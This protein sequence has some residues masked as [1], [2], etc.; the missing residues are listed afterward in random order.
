MLNKSK[1]PRN[2][3]K[4][5]QTGLCFRVCGIVDYEVEKEKEGYKWHDGKNTAL[6]V[7]FADSTE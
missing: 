7:R 4:H 1:V 2:N 6:I 3:I 5:C